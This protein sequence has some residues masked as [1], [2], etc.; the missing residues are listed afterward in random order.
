LEDDPA[1]WYEAHVADVSARYE[2][3]A[4]ESV[5]GWLFPYLPDPPAMA[6]DVGAGTG[7][8]A[9]WLAERGFDVAAIEPSEAMRGEAKRLHPSP[10]IRWFA[11]RLPDLVGPS[12]AGLSFDLI[13]VSAVWMHVPPNSR[14]RSFRKLLGLLKPGGV[15]AITLRHGPADDARGLYP[16]GP[17]ELERFC[18]ELGAYVAK[19]VDTDDRLGRKDVSWSQVAIRLPDDG[20]GALPLLR[21]IILNDAKSST[22]KLALLRVL[23]RIADSAGGLVNSSGDA[24]VAVPLGLVGLYWIRTY[25]GLVDTELPQ[26][27]RNVG[28]SG[29]GFL[30][31]A[32]LELS[33]TSPLD[34]RPGMEFHGRRALHLQQAVRDAVATITSMPVRYVT[35][36]A[37]KQVLRCIRR[38]SRNVD[39][40]RLSPEYFY[41]LGELRVPTHLWQALVRFA[42]WIE[43]A[44]V[45]EWVR[46][47]QMYSVRQGRDLDEATL[48]KALVWSDPAREV[49]VAK[50][51]AGRIL[52]DG[53]P[54][55]CVWTGKRLT[56]R[57]TDIDHCFP[58]DAWPCDALWNLMP[59]HQRVNRHEK[60]ARL[61]SAER[62]E[63]AK[64]LIEDWWAQGYLRET[65][66][67]EPRF[68]AEARAS[69][70]L[71]GQVPTPSLEDLFEGMLTQRLRLRHDQQVPEW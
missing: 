11:D 16:V 40:L 49:T 12:R 27:P 6:L 68:Y 63:S 26:Q 28:V 9:A 50:E 43:P 24:E 31:R 7:R 17:D 1:N 13:L 54:L 39:S 30:K 36:A 10:R 8:D 64:A 42:A 70:P 61:P 33:D 32:F 25:R 38:R 44:I 67:L 29:L 55:Y 48:R 35:D 65:G 34:L 4:F 52:A 56:E 22:Y 59:S 5:H 41:S 19:R 53:H 21:H 3:I 2:S 46:L 45:S 51:R 58:W 66:V 60:R 62:L 37:G 69:L 47:M 14:R 15:L 57:T 23:C 20:T 18:R 71:Y